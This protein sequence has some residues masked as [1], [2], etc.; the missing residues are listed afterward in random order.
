GAMSRYLSS[1]GWPGCEADLL[2]PP[3]DPVFIAADP[4]AVGDRS[5]GTS[6]T[7]IDEVQ[8]RPRD[9]GDVLTVSNSVLAVSCFLGHSVPES[10]P[11]TS[12]GPPT[13][14]SPNQ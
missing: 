8:A 10:V 12:T 5:R 14:G 2:Q 1:R 11:D 3:G 9:L 4:G 13:T 7:S 6:P